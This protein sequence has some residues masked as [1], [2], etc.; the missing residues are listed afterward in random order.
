MGPGGPGGE[1]Y[2]GVGRGKGIAALGASNTDEHRRY[3]SPTLCLSST[4]G[5]LAAT[6]KRMH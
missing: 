6:S 1:N 3:A 4:V 2:L 5:M